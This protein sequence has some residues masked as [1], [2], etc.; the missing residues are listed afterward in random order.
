MDDC[1]S[2]GTAPAVPYTSQMFP[3][4]LIT[5]LALFKV[6]SSAKLQPLLSI[7]SNELSS[8]ASTV[9][10]SG[11]DLLVETRTSD[12]C[13]GCILST[14][15]SLYSFED[16]LENVPHVGLQLHEPLD[17]SMVGLTRIDGLDIVLVSGCNPEADCATNS[18]VRVY[19]SA[20]GTLL[21]NQTIFG[22]SSDS[23]GPFP[24][25]S[26]TGAF[27]AVICSNCAPD[28]T[29]GACI[30][31]RATSPTAVLP[32]TFDDMAGQRI[33]TSLSHTPPS[34]NIF[35]CLLDS[36]LV[37]PAVNDD[38]TLVVYTYTGGLYPGGSFVR[39]AVLTVPRNVTPNEDLIVVGASMS[40]QPSCPTC[41]VLAQSVVALPD[42]MTDLVLLW[43]PVQLNGSACDLRRWEFTRFE[44]PSPDLTPSVA[45]WFKPSSASSLS[46]FILYQNTSV[47]EQSNLDW[48]PAMVYEIARNDT[49][50]ALDKP[51]QVQQ[52]HVQPVVFP[53]RSGIVAFTSM[54]IS[55][56]SVSNRGRM[57]AFDTMA[58]RGYANDTGLP[59]IIWKTEVWGDRKG[60][61]SPEQ[62]V[63]AA[64][65]ILGLAIGLSTALLTVAVASY[66][67][68]NG[69]PAHMFRSYQMAGD[70]HET[71]LLVGG[72]KDW[73]ARYGTAEA[74]TES[75]PT[76]HRLSRGLAAAAYSPA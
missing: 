10:H 15:V 41:P 19:T 52:L 3:R 55:H 34:S 48:Q 68:W 40:W 35:S 71:S 69:L 46:L 44:S 56:V 72:A 30:F 25:V 62:D 37:L 7:Q 24:V 39:T 14:N 65:L 58:I 53:A 18:F 73:S 70:M 22:F 75:A 1:A 45:E 26:P 29:D 51:I 64:P 63:F 20:N 23:R 36:C 76:L 6:S 31:P 17:E 16:S 59:V 57:V 2:R 66:W 43:K 27:L 54:V 67:R 5:V 50:G 4:R 13:E 49:S 11:F 61:P 28:G 38:K 33:P 42:Q 60:S 74:P 47:T 9:E 21:S 12:S 32:V 8:L